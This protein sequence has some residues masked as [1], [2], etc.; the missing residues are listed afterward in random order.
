MT[1]PPALV[2]AVREQRSVLFFGA[3]ASYGAVSPQNDTIPMAV[4]LAKEIDREFLDGQFPGESF[5][6]VYDYACSARDVRTVQRFVQKRLIG[7]EPAPHHLLI[8]RF[9]WAGLAGTNYDLIIERAY[10]IVGREAAQKLNVWR[11]DNSK[12]S[13]HT[14]TTSVVYDKIHGCI[15]DADDI[16]PPLVASTEQLIGFRNGREGQI[17]TFLEWA[18]TKTVIFCGYRFGDDN[19]RTIFHEI[20][21]EGDGRPRHYLV[22]RNPPNVAISYWSDR[23][24]T[25][26]SATFSNFIN[27]LDNQISTSQ[28]RLSSVQTVVRRSAFT[29]H[30]SVPNTHESDD[31]L[32]YLNSHIDLVHSD[33]QISK[34]NPEQFYK[35]YNQGWSPIINSLDVRRSITHEIITDHIISSENPT[36]QRVAVVKGHAGAGK[37]ILLR[38]L[39]WETAT[40]HGKLTFFAS[41][42]HKIEIDQFVEILDLTNEDVYVFVDNVAEHQSDVKQL[43]QFFSKRRRRL[44]LIIAESF[45]IWDTTCRDIEEIVSTEYEMRHLSAHEIGDLI[46]KLKK[47]NSLGHLSSLT[48][49]KQVQALSQT[50]GRQL[51]VALIEAT[52]GL[53]LIEIL[54]AEYSSI[55]TPEARQLYLDICCLHRFGPPVRAGIISRLHDISFE[56][57]KEKF[58]QP[59]SH[60]VRLREDSRTGDYVYE[61]RHSFI[62]GLVYEEALHTSEERFENL[63][64]ILTKLNPAYSYDSEVVIGLVKADQ[65][66]K[67]ISNPSRVRQL[68]DIGEANFG[69]NIAI[70]HQRSIFE[71]HQANSISGLAKVEELLRRAIDVEPHNRSLKHTLAEIHLKRSRLATNEVEVDSWRSKAVALASNLTN[72]TSSPYPF[73]TI[74]KV[75]LDEIREALAQGDEAKFG[76]RLGEALNGFE[77][78]LR[79]AL[80]RFPNDSMLLGVEGEFFQLLSNQPRAEDAFRKAFEQNQRSTIAARRLVKMLRAR[81]AH[82]DAEDVLQIAL[83][84]N[85]SDKTL[86]FEISMVMLSSAPDA[87][88]KRSDEILY[89]LRRAFTSLG[90]DFYAQFWYARQLFVAGNVEDALSIYSGLR[91]AK[92]GFS[93]K[94]RVR[95]TIRDSMGEARRYRGTV[96]VDRAT[97]AIF[98]NNEPSARVF[99]HKGDTHESDEAFAVGR[100][101]TYTIGFNL[102]GPCAQKVR[103]D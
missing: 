42:V 20:I 29:K 49:D 70:L 100:M 75:K 67:A 101:A 81:K 25:V 31:L 21:K 60:I 12:T 59:L 3:G 61:A 5:R 53:P 93:E 54:K 83:E 23:R 86:H 87:D 50:Y 98:S 15:T 66:T 55:P 79:T 68:Y 78:T 64:R 88:Q 92:V 37:T 97:H 90:S 38:R 85:P 33:I 72:R 18:K 41:R 35:G 48:R 40:I 26:I 30:I 71:L 19:L 99:Y 11:S 8:P 39:A 73:H 65:L 103:F 27:D 34:P 6:V 44:I 91:D 45:N 52:S 32:S 51:L 69:S 17:A 58:F 63:S 89:H 95:G 2:D 13:D 56:Q 4:D 62:A 80:Q 76:T 94:T 57:F 1:I 9:S 36:L 46:D 102:L 77:N 96:V 43:V 14:D 74:L 84:S 10:Q 82:G 22:L 28:K 16:N 24:V 47:A 7:F